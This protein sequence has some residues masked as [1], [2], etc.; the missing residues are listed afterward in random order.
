[1]ERREK[2]FERAVFPVSDC[3]GSKL[4]DRFRFKYIDMSRH[5]TLSEIESAKRAAKRLKHAEV[6]TFTLRE[7]AFLEYMADWFDDHV[8]FAMETPPDVPTRVAQ[9]VRAINEFNERNG[10]KWRI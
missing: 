4:L 7:L 2:K 9:K 6:E 3:T 1:M 8:K 10:I 5:L